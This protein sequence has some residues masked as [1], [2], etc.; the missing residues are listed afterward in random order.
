MPET[1]AHFQIN[2]KFII[3]V[4]KIFQEMFVRSGLKRLKESFH[5]NEFDGENDAFFDYETTLTVTH[6]KEYSKNTSSE[7]LL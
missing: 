3:L 4:M 6:N 1:K 5:E 7:V 2:T